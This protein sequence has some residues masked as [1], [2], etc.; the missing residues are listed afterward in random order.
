MNGVRTRLGP[1][2]P[3]AVLT[4]IPAAAF[5]LPDLLGGHLVMTGDNVQQNYPLHVL[6]G[7]MLRRAQLPFWNPYLFSGTPL[8]A[9]FNAGAFYPLVGLFVIL[10]D[11]AAWVATEVILFSL[12]GVGMYLFLRALALSTTACVLAALTFVGSGVVL[13]QANHVDMTEGF[14]SIPFMLL[15]VLHIVRDGRWRWSVLLGLG[16]ALVIFGGAPEA[17]LDEALLLLVYAAVS[18]GFDRA[19]WRR[20]L[21]RCGAGAALALSLAAVQWLPG[22]TAIA[23]SQR[24]GLGSSFA[25]SGS[26]PP[27][28]G[29]LSLVPYLY[30]GFGHLGEAMFFSTYN[31]P[32]V[33]IYMGILPVIAVL[34]LWRRRW[35]SRLAAR[36]RVAWYVVGLIGILLALGAHTPL[37]H[38]F[39]SIPLYGEQR[40]QSRNMIDVAV[41][42]SVLFA[43]WIDRR[44]DAPEDSVVLDRRIALVPFTVVLA[45]AGWA[46]ID[47]A[48]LVMTLSSG[49]GSAAEAHTV[50][51]A[52]LIALGFCL[53]AGLIVWFRPVLPP[54]R[55]ILLV[56]AFTVLDLG[57]S[58]GTSELVSLPS[59]AVLAG[60]TAIEKHVAAH[61]TPG[62]RFVVYD[63]Q[64]Y[65]N[66]SSD[67][68]S[69]LPDDNILA[70]LPSV[71]GYA[72]IVSGNYDAQT[73]T[74][75]TGQLNVGLFGAG[76]PDGLDLQEI[77][78]APEYF[79]LPL[80]GAPTTLRGVHQV[81]EAPGTDPVLPMGFDANVAE[82]A[83]PTYPAPRRAMVTG[84]SSTWLFGE[85]LGVTRAG[86]LLASPAAGAQIRFGR[87]SADGA[88]RWGTRVTVAAGARSAAGRLPPGQSVGLAVQVLSGL[89]PAQQ[90]TIAVGRRVYELDGPLSDVVRPGPWRPQG[91][92]DD[93][94]LF[95]RTGSP[96]PV[97]VVARAG[98]P[99]PHVTVVS[100]SADAEIVSV[101]TASPTV[102]VRD[103]AWD[104]GWH[105]SVTVNRG[106]A[107][108]VRVAPRGLM[109]QVRIPAGA[110]LVTFTYRP[111]HWLVASALS[112]GASLV[113]FVLALVKV[114][115]QRRGGRRGRRERHGRHGG[116]PGRR[117]EERT[118]ALARTGPPAAPPARDPYVVSSRG[119]P[120]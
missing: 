91:S 109:E 104:D 60:T 16:G 45:L 55:W 85:S 81:A 52:T 37:E 71:G 111:P 40:L 14:A 6:V 39:D 101:R 102:L 12:I 68:A 97:Y 56:A 5:V 90:A 66:G 51:E 99:P 7:S 103:V 11:R 92:V 22:I 75:T 49:S 115:G 19:R 63:P 86:V 23:N 42:T 43:G 47:P 94:S 41:A 29:L 77:V 32:E 20:V 113:L 48:S 74:H 8:L 18:A 54:H 58:A 88:V 3:Y 67:L 70:G 118:A 110:D 31:L 59:N 62:G 105:A 84:E 30:G 13:G 100:D 114:F 28:Y 25:S 21:T 69:G 50:R 36:E 96:H 87:V 107:T 83:Y 117:S 112:V 34:S 93:Y 76:D 46:L 61:L 17:M 53:A 80:R 120:A 15:A 72:S 82:G 89:L 44:E 116:R 24:S 33:E 79:L 106:L 65:R 95:G 4:G 27:T 78:T 26:F 10:P 9:G 35:P 73:S 2:W 57:L 98:R 1:L 108:T 119:G 38:L 64:G